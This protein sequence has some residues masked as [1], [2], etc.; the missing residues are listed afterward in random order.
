MVIWLPLVIMG[1]IAFAYFKEGVFTAFT[2][3][4]NVL[5]AGF[6]AFNFWE[7]IA[8]LLERPLRGSFLNGME[9]I[10]VLV[11]LFALVLGL[12]RLATNN[13]AHKQVVY[14]LVAQQFGGAFIGLLT[15]YLVSGF[16]I[17]VFQTLPWHENFLDFQPRADNE[18]GLRRVFPPDRVWLAMM[19]HAGALPLANR[20]DKQSAASVYERSITFDQAGTFEL[21]Y[22]RYRRHGDGRRPLDY[23]GELGPQLHRK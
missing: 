15:G 21:R 8:D 5:L 14:P 22:Q 12:L 1:I 7:P 17:C 20:T 11:F 4:I 9:D 2:M 3:L 13:L 10:L 19:R 23:A 16:L 18:P 6:I